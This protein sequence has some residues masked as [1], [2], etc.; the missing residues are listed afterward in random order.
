[1]GQL[2]VLASGVDTLYFSSRGTLREGR[3]ESLEVCRAQ[4]GG[5][6]LPIAFGEGG[7]AY[8]HVG[9]SW[10]GYPHWLKAP[11]FDVMVGASDPFPPVYVQLRAQ[12]IHEQ[13]VG[14]ALA[15]VASHLASEFFKGEFTVD[16]SRLDVYAD[17]QGWQPDALD[18]GRIVTRARARTLY[19]GRSGDGEL[20]EYGRRLSGFSFGRGDFVARI[21]DKRLQMSVIGTDWQGAVWK[22]EDPDAQ[23][24]RIEFQARR[25]VLVALGLRTADDGVELRQGLWDY[26]AKWLSL[27]EP[28]MHERVS[29]WPVSALW[30]WV[31][32][33]EVGEPCAPLVRQRA[34]RADRRRLIAGWTGYSAS[35]AALQ[36]LYGLEDTAAELGMSTR[37]Y[38]TETGRSFEGLVEQKRSLLPERA[39]PLCQYSLGHLSSFNYTP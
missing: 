12:F 33:V 26:G 1:M 22:D 35:F 32:A 19:E 11:G 3:M 5:N 10:R 37:A 34:A 9:H 20:F 8:V 39:D 18:F 36:R 14:A 13:G 25:R 16:L 17:I 21:Y 31:Q 15:D 28:S 7:G 6:P 23:V 4:S 29:R 38:L 27:R 24:W 2:R 30:R